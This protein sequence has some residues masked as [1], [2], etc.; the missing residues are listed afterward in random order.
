M[1]PQDAM[2]LADKE[3]NGLI[4]DTMT[5]RIKPLKLPTENSLVSP[6]AFL[7]LEWQRGGLERILNLGG[8]DKR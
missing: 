4:I 8:G 3:G 7:G 1:T 6:I 5:A 2:M